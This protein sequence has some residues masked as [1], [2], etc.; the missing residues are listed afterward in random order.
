MAALPGQQV[1][2]ADGTWAGPMGQSNW[3]GDVRNPIGEAT[4][5]DNTTAGYNILGNINAEITIIPQL[6]FKTT[7]GVQASFWDNR[8]WSPK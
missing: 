7:G 6:K 1:Y 5:N 3:Y 2:N 4:I 8:N